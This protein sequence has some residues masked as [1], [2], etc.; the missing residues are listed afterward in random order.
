M[1]DHARKPAKRL[2]S[3]AEAARYWDVSPRTVR[4]RIADGSLRGFKIGRLVKVDINEVDSL[5]RPIP[6]AGNGIT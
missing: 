2:V 4:R 6:S 3:L 1:P 5:I